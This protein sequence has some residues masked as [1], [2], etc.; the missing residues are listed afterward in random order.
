[1]PPGEFIPVAEA[2]GLIRPLGAWVLG[3]A[4]R[5][6]RLWR[7]AGLELVMAVNLSPA[8]LRHGGMLSEI[9]NAL[10]AS[11]LDPGSLELEITENLL[12]EHTEGATDRVLDGIGARGIRLAL[13]DFGT[14]YSSLASLKRLPVSRIKIDRSFV[15][16]IGSDPEDEAVVRAMVS[17]GH[18]L[19]KSVV[20]EG[21]ENEAQLA[22]LRRLGCDVA[23]GFLL[24][25][26]RTAAELGPLL[27]RSG[28]PRPESAR[29]SA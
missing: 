1:V 2:S 23:Q 12:L 29:R 28:S 7:D 4:C 10:C 16:D 5:Q 11:G 8:Q 19:G 14:G 27:A 6:A 25:R 9:D 20:A 15:R 26:P 22:F 18:A 3:E 13:D 17:L 24:A 21:V